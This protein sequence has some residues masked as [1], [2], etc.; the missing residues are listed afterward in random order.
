[1]AAGYVCCDQRAKSPAWE[2]VAVGVQAKQLPVKW[3]W[4]FLD[5]ISK[6]GQ[7]NTCEIYSGIRHSPEK[8]IF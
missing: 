4:E 8:Y 1:M 2:V 6:L 7:D 5:M 3:N